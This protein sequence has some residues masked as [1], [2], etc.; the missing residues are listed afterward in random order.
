MEK[1]TLYNLWKKISQKNKIVIAIDGNS[2]PYNDEEIKTLFY[3]N[4]FEQFE[5]L[6]I[7]SKNDKNQKS[8]NLLFQPKYKIHNEISIER[9]NPHNVRVTG[10][11]DE[12]IKSLFSIELISAIGFGDFA[13]TRENVFSILNEKELRRIF[14]DGKVFIGNLSKCFSALRPWIN[15][16]T[17]LNYNKNNS[18]L[19]SNWNSIYTA[20]YR[21]FIS[22]NLTNV[23]R[24]VYA[25]N[26][27]K[28]KFST[29][30]NIK[31]YLDAI[32]TRMI[33]ILKTRDTLE[34]F[35]MNSFKSTF[36]GNNYSSNMHYFF[37]YLLILATGIIDSI[38]RVLFWS[39]DKQIKNYMEVT[40]KKDKSGKRY[41]NFLEDLSSKNSILADYL[42]SDD[43]QY[44]FELIYSI[45]NYVAHG[46]LP[47][48]ISLQ[49]YFG[50]LHGDLICIQVDSE[51]IIKYLTSR[52]VIE[53]Q[54]IGIE[55]LRQTLDETKNLLD[56]VLF[57]RHVVK[58]IIELSENIFG[59]LSLEHKIIDKEEM[60]KY[61]LY[62][63]G[64]Q[65]KKKNDPLEIEMLDWFLSTIETQFP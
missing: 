48:R 28:T 3:I 17:E 15:E 47:N 14:Y 44:F 35:K 25:L 31:D 42:D 36:G 38:G 5:I 33:H 23:K 59:M 20:A 21:D 37:G 39:I 41:K 32:S 2:Y 40:I 10:F 55:I 6:Y 64:S 9:I 12:K 57:A 46:I 24:I 27:S 4:N 11:Q 56:P 60:D 52:N 22:P 26:D 54:D 53:S 61:H 45:R 63:N 58:K 49:G 43:T 34:S 50:G 29:G 51:L 18:I 19:I 7:S 62:K 1:L 16:Q 13:I 65:I 30:D 8:N